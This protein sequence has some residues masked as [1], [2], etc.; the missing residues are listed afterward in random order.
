MI[1]QMNPVPGRYVPLEEFVKSEDLKID[2]NTLVKDEQEL[3]KTCSKYKDDIKEVRENF[4]CSDGNAKLKTEVDQLLDTNQ[5]SGLHSLM[6]YK[7]NLA[8]CKMIEV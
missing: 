2:L 7:D 5:L 8:L 4:S 1:R 3:R 6:M